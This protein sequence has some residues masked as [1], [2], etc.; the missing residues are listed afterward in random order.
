[1]TIALATETGGAAVVDDSRAPH[2][3]LETAKVRLI[4][5]IEVLAHANVQAALGDGWPTPYL[6]R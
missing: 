4:G 2:L 1:V 5:S 3:R 6:L